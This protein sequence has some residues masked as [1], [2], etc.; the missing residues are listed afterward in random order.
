M[1]NKD[2]EK[3]RIYQ[4]EW[5]KR[6]KDKVIAARKRYKNKHRERLNKVELARR[7]PKH[8]KEAYGMTVEDW[9]VMFESQDG[10]CILCGKHQSELKSKICVDHCHTSGRV[11]GMLCR[12]C[13]AQL[14]W[15]EARKE[16]I[17]EYLK[18]PIHDTCE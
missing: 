5:K 4:R 12:Q 2:K 13:N 3:N 17:K 15:Y 6:N 14:G 1:P 8:L 16:L 11:R 7:W 9:Q 18:E 10:K